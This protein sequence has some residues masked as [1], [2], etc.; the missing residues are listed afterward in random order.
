M[1]GRPLKLIEHLGYPGGVDGASGRRAG[2]GYGAVGGGGG[3]TMP[4][5]MMAERGQ[6]A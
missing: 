2:R 4:K 5:I 6:T 1:G 3:I